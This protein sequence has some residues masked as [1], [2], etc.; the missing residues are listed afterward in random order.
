[1]GGRSLS[2]VLPILSYVIL[3]QGVYNSPE[4]QSVPTALLGALHAIAMFA[5]ALIAD[6]K[7]GRRFLHVYVAA[8][9]M[10]AF[11]FYFREWLLMAWICLLAALGLG[12]SLASQGNL[13]RLASTLQVLLCLV[14]LFFAVVPGTL[15]VSGLAERE[16]LRLISIITFAAWAV[17]HLISAV[18]R[19]R[20]RIEPI[21][22][23]LFFLLCCLITTSVA[24]AAL[25]QP[26]LDY[27]VVVLSVAATAFVLAAAG[28]LLWSPAIGEGLSAVFFRHVLSL[29]VHFDDWMREMNELADKSKDDRDFWWRAMALLQ[30][31]TDLHGVSWSD[32]GEEV[33]IGDKD[34][35]VLSLPLSEHGLRLH[36]KS[37][38]LPTMAF[39]L[40]LLARVAHEYRLSKEREARLTAEATMRS[41]HEMGA[42]TT[43]DIKNLLHA[44]NL[45]C[46]SDRSGEK[47][48]FGDKGK[49]QLRSLAGR[50][51]TSLARLAGAEAHHE[52]GGLISL[53][54]WWEGAVKRHANHAVEFSWLEDVDSE[55]KIPGELFDRAL[56]NML[57]N[58]LRKSGRD[59]GLAVSVELGQAPSLTV[60]DT[61][62][63]IPQ[64]ILAKLFKAPVPS[65]D[66]M[67]IGLFQLATSAVGVGYEMSVFSNEK[68]DVSLRLEKRAGS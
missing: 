45:L 28:W 5:P 61:G 9:V 23:T 33:T 54:A 55:A 26:H 52:H 66:G 37:R 29:G 3:L 47:G 68:G 10:A 11:A 2:T 49:E 20:A 53:R 44:I 13:R 41:A 35:H 32:R 60:R 63:P 51:E 7:A 46:A 25:L 4:L 48:G 34:G 15:G 43:H 58:A 8:V 6:R 50:L 12:A 30:E 19:G 16:D 38:V 36:S 64:G 18:D 1:M 56:E 17:V 59:D 39:N 62:S 40:W 14:L 67:G 22:C 27:L 57:H 21:T 42:R 31:R 65:S 24:L